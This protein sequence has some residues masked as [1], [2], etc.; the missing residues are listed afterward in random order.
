M[1][2]TH[3]FDVDAYSCNCMAWTLTKG[4]PKEDRSCKHL[5]QVLGDE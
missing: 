3:S 1:S 4:R 5:R 2:A